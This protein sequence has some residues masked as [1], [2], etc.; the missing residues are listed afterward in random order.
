MKAQAASASALARIARL[1]RPRLGSYLVGLVVFTLTE[2]GFYVSIPLAVKLMIDAALAGDPA[3]LWRGV[4]FIVGV[5]VVGGVSFVL[6][7]Y[8]FVVVVARLT[9][10]HRKDVFAHTLRLPARFFESRHSGDI[11]SRLT[12]DVNVLRNSYDWP[13]WNL[14]VTAV[15]GAGAAAAMVALDW[16][17]SLVLIASSLVFAGLNAAAARA[18]G[19]TSAE[20]Q[21]SQ[22][23]V[24]EALGNILAGY[25][26]IKRFRLEARLLA[27]LEAPNAAAMENSLRRVRQTAVLDC[28]NG[29]IGW[30]NF[31]GVL[32]A[33]AWLAGR[34]LLSFGTMLAMVNLLWNVNRCIRE[35]G[36][37]LAQFQGYLAGAARVEELRAEPEENYGPADADAA[38]TAGAAAA[39][40]IDIELKDLVFAYDGRPPAITG[41]SLKIEAGA[42][43]ALAGPSGG[44]KSTILKLLL[45]FY[46]PASGDIL[47]GGRPIA[48]YPL[49]AL[50]D[51]FAYVPQDLFL[52]SGTIAE[53]I[54]CARPDAS[55]EDIVRAAQAARAH[56]FIAGF[57]LGYDTAVGERGVKLSGGQR[58][59]IAIARAFLK[60][61]PVLLLDE[62][63]SSL[64]SRSERLIQEALRELGERRTVV[65][66]AHRLSTIE[67]ADAIFVVEA[68]AVVERGAHAELLAS[69]G[70]FKRLYDLQ[71]RAGGEAGEAN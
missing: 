27:Q 18:I 67:A 33:G 59:R 63:T 25:P 71:Y 8:L 37:Q 69:G 58:Q 24:T 38:G 17:V 49:S 60:D 53:N 32:A 42:F 56:E 68:G 28:Y 46:T 57:E 48:D 62:A 6:F 7:M 55:M 50:R 21:K 44:G 34:G 29:L 5:S 15:A 52:F 11:V 36:G 70:V 9:A 40:G 16:R 1:V 3:S 20:L 10:G 19:K 43:V 51:L 41:V 12:N 26:I 30:I 13:L 4:R 61:A 64:D 65:A 14:L 54:G 39:R 2:A 22:G 47:I 35:I 23:D 45:G 66:V 31:G